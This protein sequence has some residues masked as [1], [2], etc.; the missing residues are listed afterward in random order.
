MNIKRLLLI[1]GLI[2]GIGLI[3]IGQNKKA[4]KAYETFDA[5]EYYLA[6]DEFKRAY[7]QITDKK[8]KMHIAFYIAECY[9]ITNNSRQAALW[10]GKVVA[11]DYENPVA[12]LYYADAL[13][14]NQNY[15]EARAQYMHYKDLVPDDPRGADGIISCDQSLEWIDNPTSYQVEEMKF[16]NSRNSD[17]SPAYARDDYQELYFTSSRDET[18][19]NAEHGGT[20]QAFSDI[21]YSTMDKKGKWSTP[22]PLPEPVN[23]EAEE[24]TPVLSNNYNTMYFTRC[25]VSKRKPLGCEIF[26]VERNGNSW[27]KEESLGIASDSLVV[28]HPAISKDELA[29]YFVSDIEGSTK[30][31]DGKNSKD[32]WMVTRDNAGGKWG[33]PVNLGSPVNTPGDEVFPY[34]HADGSL[35]FSSNGHIGM[36]GLDIY[37]A[38]KTE[39]G[40]WEIE[41]MKYPVNSSSDDFGITFENERES[42]Y[43][44]SSRKGRG[45]DDIYAFLLPPLKFS[46]LGTVLNEKTDEV[47]PDALVKSIGSDGITLETN[48][49]N[50][51]SFRFLLKPGTDYVFIA[52]KKGFLKGKERESTK[53]ITQSTEF[54]TQI[55]LS[56]VEIPIELENIFFDLDKANLRPESMVSLDR[57]VETLNDN[58]TIVIELGSHTDFRATD[59]Y[60]ND[61]S[62]R[63]A[64][65]VVN[66]LI[67][68]GI[69]RDR[70]VAKGYGET[71]PKVVDKKDNEAYP[72]LPVGTVLSEQFITSLADDD[73]QEMANFLNRRTEFRVLRE[74]YGGE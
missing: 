3:A 34:V 61:L 37:K 10:Y 57:L 51:G 4:I 9:R 44:S 56:S 30:T 18:V 8:E 1:S 53:G 52:E 22:L 26:K 58:P 65:S 25:N 55:Y 31:P 49:G 33:S 12:I 23:T 63:R 40:Q 48:T 73:Q 62:R 72:F 15:E 42:G 69:A 5:G 47:I 38:T 24:G 27:G 54:K 59:E 11:R 43:F 71:T 19:G 60:N 35:Y 20:G 46:I 41:N 14:M 29:L 13:K 36:G 70:L 17:Y 7:Q 6:I 50:D 28:A 21:F 68:K 39:T 67:E 66:Y 16:I 45:D 74:D 2:F 32:I 64:Q